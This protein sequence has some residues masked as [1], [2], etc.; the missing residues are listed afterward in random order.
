M[1]ALIVVHG[2]HGGG[3]VRNN[4]LADA[5]HYILNNLT[6]DNEL[7]GQVVVSSSE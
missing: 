2:V 7:V 5:D 6:M 1:A 4:G 3:G